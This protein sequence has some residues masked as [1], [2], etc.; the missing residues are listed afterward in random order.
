MSLRK[1]APL[2]LPNLPKG[3]AAGTKP[4]LEWVAPTALLID[5]TYQRDLSERSMRLIRKMLEG[6][7][8]NRMKPPI[9]AKVDGGLHVIDGQHTAIVAATLGL[10]EI[11]IF[12]VDAPSVDE[13]ARAF[14][15]HNTD[16]VIVQPISIYHALVAAG[17]PDALD[18]AATCRR[19]GVRI[20]YVTASTLVAEGDTMAVG[21]IRSLVRRRGVMLARKTLEVL[22]KAKRAP[23]GAAEIIAVEKIVCEDAKGLNPDE[24]IA[25]IRVDGDHGIRD[26][27]ARALDDGIPQWRA[28]KERWLPKLKRRTAA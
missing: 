28:L 15:G 1:V 20:R 27:R 2:N 7:A 5:E 6:F 12:L 16:R 21:T 19:A 25:V 3:N 4:S 17:D 14:V 9:V 13:R 22:V 18:V 11:P 10:P 24:L 23:I 26:A 8:W